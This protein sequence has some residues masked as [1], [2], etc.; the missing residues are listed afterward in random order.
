MQSKNDKF[1][2]GSMVFGGTGWATHAVG[3]DKYRILPDNIPQLS[4][5][6]GVLGM[7]G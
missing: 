6:L 5:F 7:P 3:D 1:P 2:V 4:Y